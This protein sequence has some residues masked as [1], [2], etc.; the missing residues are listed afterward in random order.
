MQ[1]AARGA[2]TS[3]ALLEVDVAL[4]FLRL[5]APHGIVICSGCLLFTVKELSV[6][7]LAIDHDLSL[8]LTLLLAH[9]PESARKGSIVSIY[10]HSDG[11]YLL[12]PDSLQDL[13]HPDY[14]AVHLYEKHL[15]RDVLI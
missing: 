4:G 7:P 13:Q 1:P 2:V 15:S 14:H 12:Q 6:G 8:P 3:E 9:T 10:R 11:P 5:Q